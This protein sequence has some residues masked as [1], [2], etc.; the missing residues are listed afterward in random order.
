MNPKIDRYTLHTLARDI[1]DGDVD[2]DHIPEEYSETKSKQR[3][4]SRRYD[5]GEF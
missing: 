2:E 1:I 5:D 4:K 3:K